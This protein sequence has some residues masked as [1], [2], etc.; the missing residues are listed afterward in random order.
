MPTP[1]FVKDLRADIG[2]KEMWLPGV[3]AVVI[4]KHDDAGAALVEPQVL[5]V[6][7]ADNGRWTVTSGILDLGED[8]APAGVR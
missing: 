2:T 5:L 1:D 8:P 3:S 7:R 6:R 4:R